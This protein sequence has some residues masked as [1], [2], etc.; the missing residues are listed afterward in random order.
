MS[1]N[2][3]KCLSFFAVGD[4]AMDN[5][6]YIKRALKLIGQRYDFRGKVGITLSDGS[7]LPGA[8]HNFSDVVPECDFC[9]WLTGFTE[10]AEVDR[11]AAE[12]KLAEVSYRCGTLFFS[13]H[14][15]GK[16]A[17]ETALRHTR[18]EHALDIGSVDEHSVFMCW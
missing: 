4:S 13:A 1:N 3:P 16:P 7:I 15:P 18:Y 14:G 11:E 10:A 9:I 17:N 12:A 6:R 5:E 8:E 2:N